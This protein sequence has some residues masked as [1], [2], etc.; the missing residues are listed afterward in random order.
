MQTE[1]H[2]LDHL[3]A[4]L[5]QKVRCLE[6][7]PDAEVP[8]AFMD[9]LNLLEQIFAFEDHLMESHQFPGARS[10]VEQHARILGGL[11]RTHSLVMNGACDQGRH[12]GSCLLMRWFEL[13]NETLDACLAVWL[14][15]M[16]TNRMLPLMHRGALPALALRELTR[17]TSAPRRPY[18][19]AEKND[20]AASS[21]H[22]G[23]GF[24][25]Q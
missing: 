22:S 16:Q 18:V 19:K 5:R 10:H 20:A 21:R 8:Q 3:Y 9:L 11:H 7:C 13:H 12:A 1:L 2:A 4:Q 6:L 14:Q 24:G 17:I 23:Q 15:S 25:E